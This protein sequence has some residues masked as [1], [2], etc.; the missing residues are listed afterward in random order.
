MRRRSRSSW[1]SR[2]GCESDRRAGSRAPSNDSTISELTTYLIALSGVL[3][4]SFSAVFVRLAAV[5]PV[6]AAF[7]RAAYAVPVLALIC[8]AVGSRDHRDRR[9]RLLAFASGIALAMDLALW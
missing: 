5:S 3:A 6:T 8:L 9:A 4:I 2:A 7:F 1:R